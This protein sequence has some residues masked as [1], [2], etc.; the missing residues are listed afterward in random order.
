MNKKIDEVKIFIFTSLLLGLIFIADCAIL[1]GISLTLNNLEFFHDKVFTVM[2]CGT[3]FF[4]GLL[5]TSIPFL[6]V[7][8]YKKEN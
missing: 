2:L 7:Y 8:K 5:L 4:L 1:N 6:A 3:L